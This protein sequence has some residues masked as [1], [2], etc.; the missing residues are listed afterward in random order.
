MTRIEYF[1]KVAEFTAKRSTC[2]KLQVGCVL[3][4]ENNRMAAVGYNSSIK[5]ELHCMDAG[6]LIHED[7][8]IRC[9]HAEVAA[10]A[11]LTQQY[12]ELT[13]FVTHKPCYHCFKSLVANGVN[14]IYYL[15]EYYD[16]ARKILNKELN[17]TMFH[18]SMID[19][20]R[21]L[22]LIKNNDRNN[23]IRLKR[24]IF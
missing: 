10:L 24:W 1:M 16:K 12:N 20:P 3:V 23:I 2:N 22:W 8:C 4:D 5:G 18:V 13:A 6:W 21:E 15:E 17:I 14:T 19:N 7:H 9:P 11:N